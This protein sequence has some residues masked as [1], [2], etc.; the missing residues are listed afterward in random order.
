MCP[1]QRASVC[2]IGSGFSGAVLAVELA[3][4]GIDVLVL[5]SGSTDPDHRLDQML[6]RID[7]SGRTELRFGFARQ[8]G[9]ASNLW[10]GRVAPLEAIDFERRE[11][12]P[13]SGWPHAVE[14]EPTACA[15]ESSHSGTTHSRAGQSTP[16]FAASRN[17]S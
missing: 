15:A 11:W 7:V 12:I 9:G 5:E 4:A 10:A 13:H 3:A 16:E 14:L 6:D 2:V 17:S 1:A 8:L